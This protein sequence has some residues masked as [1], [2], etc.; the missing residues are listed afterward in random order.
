M[1]RQV[2]EQWYAGHVD[3]DL[4]DHAMYLQGDVCGCCGVSFETGGTS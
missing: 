4:G 1:S 2:I 3:A